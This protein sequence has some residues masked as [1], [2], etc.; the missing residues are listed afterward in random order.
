MIIEKIPY[1]NKHENPIDDELI[2]IIRPKCI[3]PENFKGCYYCENQISK[4]KISK[5]K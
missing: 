5:E 3:I 1:C 4:T 2:N